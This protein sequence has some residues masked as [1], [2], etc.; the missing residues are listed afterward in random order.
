[1]KYELINH[2]GDI[3]IKITEN[4]LIEI[5][6]T[7]AFAMFN[8]MFDVKNFS[9]EIKKNFHL[10]ANSTSD[11]L[12]FWLSEL[13]KTF[14][15]DKIVFSKFNLIKIENNVLQAEAY[16]ESFDEKKHLMKREIKAVTFHELYVKKENDKWRAQV[17]FDV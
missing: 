3:G 2:T 5:F 15:L 14:F 4:T 17:I 10:E 11:L 9:D 1:M 12:N 8:I 7:A 6:N 16:G 13:L